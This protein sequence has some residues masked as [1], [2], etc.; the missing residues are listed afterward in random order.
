MA[1]EL[2]ALAEN[3]LH[4]LVEDQARPKQLQR[5]LGEG[6]L[7]QTHAQRDLPAQV[8]VRPPLGLLVRYSLLVDHQLCGG[9]SRR[10][11]PG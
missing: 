9:D 5:A 6:P 11:D 3:R 10:S 1:S 2:Q 7:I 4:T 8:E